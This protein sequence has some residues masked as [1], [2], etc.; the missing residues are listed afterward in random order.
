[1]LELE[2]YLKQKLNELKDQHS[3]IGDVR[4]I[5]LFGAIEF[6]ESKEVRKPLEKDENGNY[7]LQSFISKLRE[8]GLLSFGGAAT[9][10]VAPPLIITKE[11][12]DEVF[13][14]LDEV[15]KYADE[16]VDSRK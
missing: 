5:G 2:D 10:L 9:I 7:F 16:I 14:K 3:S 15:I 13:E 8:N 1:M 4:S 12:L 11:E 6:S